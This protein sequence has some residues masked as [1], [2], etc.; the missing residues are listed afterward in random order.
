MPDVLRLSRYL[1]AAAT[2]PGWPEG[3]S[4]APFSQTLAP[5]IH[6]LM[7]LAYAEGGGSVPADF[8]AWWAATRHD[9]EFDASL[10]FVALAE[11]EPVGFLLCWTSGFVK[12]LVVHP[13]WRQRGIGGTLMRTAMGALAARGI[14]EVALKVHADNMEARRL[15]AELGFRKG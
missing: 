11:G 3:V 14:G 12:D 9:S 7:L 5:R 4:P 6:E 13:Q 8:D 2:P 1:T 15:Y 10:C